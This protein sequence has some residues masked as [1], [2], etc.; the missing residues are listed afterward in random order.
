MSWPS[1][2]LNN[3]K[4][5]MPEYEDNHSNKSDADE[6]AQTIDNKHFTRKQSDA[7]GYTK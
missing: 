4:T 1:S 2:I 7:Y 3:G 6:L 5:K